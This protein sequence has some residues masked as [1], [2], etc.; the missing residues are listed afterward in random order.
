MKNNKL[1]NAIIIKKLADQDKLLTM[2]LSDIEKQVDDLVFDSFQDLEAGNKLQELLD[3]LAIENGQKLGLTI[4]D[5]ASEF[6]SVMSDITGKAKAELIKSYEESIKAIPKPKDG[7]DGKDYIITQRDFKKIAKLVD[8]KV[9]ELKEKSPEE[10]RDMMESLKGDNRLDFKAIRGLDEKIKSLGS[11]EGKG[12]QTIG[13]RLTRISQ[14]KD[15][16]TDGV[17]NG[18]VLVYSTAQG[19]WIP[20]AGGG[21]SGGGTV[22]GTDGTYD[23]QATNEG[24]TAGNARGEN[25]VDLQTERTAATQVASGT[26]SVLIGGKGNTASGNYSSVIG[27]LFSTADST[28]STVIGGDGSGAQADDA[29]VI[30]GSENWALGTQSTVVGGASNFARDTGST[31]VGGIGND[32]YGKYATAIGGV[33]LE[34]P[35]YC[36]ATVGM[37]PTTYTANSATAHDADDRIFTVGIGTGTGARADGFRVKKDGSM[38]LPSY[39]SGTFTGT[40][41]KFLAVT[42]AGVVIEE[43]APSSAESTGP[44]DGGEL[45]AGTLNTQF[46]IS[47]GF[48]YVVDAITDPENPTVT[49]QTWTGLTDITVTTPSNLVNWIYLDA[50]NNVLQQATE[51][52]P[53]Q[54]R[55][56]IVLGY[57]VSSDGATLD[58][59]VHHPN[60][61][62]QSANSVSD[63]MK[64]IGDMN[65][66]GN[67]YSYASTDLTI[68]RSAGTTFSMNSNVFN[69]GKDPHYFDT[70]VLDPVPTFLYAYSDGAGG[71]SLATGTE[72]DPDSYDDGSGVLATIPSSNKWTIQRIAF[73][74]ITGLTVIQYGQTIYN[75]K[76]SAEAAID[77]E[78][79]DVLP[80]ISAG[81]IRTS[82]VVKKGETDLSS[83]DTVFR[84]T[85][86]FGY[87]IG[88]NAF[89]FGGQSLQDTYEISDEP[90]IETN[91]TRGALSIKRGSAADTDDVFETQNGA[92][93]Q[94]FSVN[95]NGDVKVGGHSY[96]DAE[97]TGA[98]TVDWTLGNHQY[99]LVKG[100]ITLTF[101]DP[102][103]PT[104]LILR[105][106]VDPVGGTISF[107]ASVKW[108]GGTA[109]T[110]STGSGDIDVYSFYFDGTDYYGG[111]IADFQ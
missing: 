58:S 34:A 47:D 4:K 91:S 11:V 60:A 16:D 3:S 18:Q 71:L 98:S 79:F 21:G 65:I 95:G 110:Y 22:Q 5:L 61:V 7:E 99:R 90:E 100:T 55:D 54:R 57:V 82:L 49:Q 20:G 107:P 97:V 12:N 50:S 77:S 30:G 70:S 88:N 85:G 1:L 27:S 10:L 68:K 23:I 92:G 94:T 76:E 86:K 81:G 6:N 73:S 39:G 36:E 8:V 29:T 72:I 43:D 44:V 56:Y 87:G 42:S 45:S 67:E 13:R 19:K 103:G 32:V 51:P 52:T 108:S 59:F 37:F 106:K 62:V 80:N 2:R 101:T 105:T 69:N 17:T 26:H 74:P 41:A 24:A 9:P 33:A 75:S 46:S 48:G 83:S 93:T 25:S 38:D 96:A 15:V 84:H 35:S 111:F 31:V 53:E 102:S 28:Y 14:M 66:S 40:A 109:P 89:G 64:A 63:F 78:G 104:T